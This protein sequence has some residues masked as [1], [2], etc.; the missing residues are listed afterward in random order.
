[1]LRKLGKASEA[2]DRIEQNLGSLTDPS[3]KIQPALRMQIAKLYLD[4]DRNQKVIEII[5]GVAKQW[6]EDVEVASTLAQAYQRLGDEQR[7]ASYA[8]IADAGQKETVLADRML[9]E[10]LSN[11][12]RTAQQCYQLGHLLLHKQSRE[13]GIYWLEAALQIDERFEPAHR[14]LALY[15][16]RTGQSQLAAVHKRYLSE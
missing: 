14:D 7:S 8:T 2:L 6:P 15:Y 9:F 12:N 5:E 11:P 3:L 4:V 13:N 1:V 10:L 16:D